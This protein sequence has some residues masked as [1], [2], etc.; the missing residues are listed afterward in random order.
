M[1]REVDRRRR[2]KRRAKQIQ[3]ASKGKLSTKDYIQRG[4]VVL[5]IVVILA[6]ALLFTQTYL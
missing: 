5:I 1:G 6:A 3:K 4:L 2:V